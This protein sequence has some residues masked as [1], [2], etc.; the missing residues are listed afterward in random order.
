MPWTT[1]AR[2]TTFVLGEK[3]PKW[4]T[5]E[6]VDFALLNEIVERVHLFDG[7]GVDPPVHRDVE[8][9]NIGRATLFERSFHG[10][11]K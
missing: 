6:I 2:S 10:K 4:I 8:N 11:V 7:G 1:D 5:Y 3:T 9:V